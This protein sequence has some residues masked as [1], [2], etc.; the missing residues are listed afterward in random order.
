MILYK[1]EKAR[2]EL[3]PGVR[4]LPLRERSLLLLVDGS[5]TAPELKSMYDGLAEPLVEKLLS[6]GFLTFQSGVPVL[7][8]AK[9][10][11]RVQ[12]SVSVAPPAAEPASDGDAESPQGKRSLAAARMFLFDM[13]ERI[14]AR[15]EPELAE[16]FRTALRDAKDRESMLVVSTKMSAILTTMGAPE[17]AQT[18]QMQI[19]TLLP[20]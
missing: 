12:A 10:V 1:T 17:R 11:A 20:L 5:R 18:I 4:S 15:R 13:T 9:P 2:A 8:A 7:K 19:E 14:F 16:C 3:M 6:D